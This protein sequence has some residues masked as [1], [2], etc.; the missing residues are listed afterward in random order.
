[1]G[2]DRTN[3]QWIISNIWSLLDDMLANEVPFMVAE[4][5]GIV[6]PET[7]PLNHPPPHTHTPHRSHLFSVSPEKP[8]GQGQPA[9]RQLVTQTDGNKDIIHKLAP[10]AKPLCHCYVRALCLPTVDTG[11]S[12]STTDARIFPADDPMTGT[13]VLILYTNFPALSSGNPSEWRD[14]CEREVLGHN[15]M[16]IS[17]V[18]WN[19]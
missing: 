13:E 6:P 7:R 2:A 18:C 8:A 17:Y 15:V 11:D 3:A 12:A 4:T 19:P 5:S 16:K 10:S 9:S 14:P 1:M